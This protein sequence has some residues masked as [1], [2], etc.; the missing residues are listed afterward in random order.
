MGATRRPTRWID[1][2]A[3]AVW[4]RSASLTCLTGGLIFLASARS[5]MAAAEIDVQ[6]PMDVSIANGGSRDFGSVNAGTNKTLTFTVRNSGAGGL[7]LTGAPPVVIT[8][9]HAADFTVTAQ[10]AS[11]VPAAVSVLNAGFESP[12]VGP[13][14]FTNYKMD[15]FGWTFGTKISLWEHSSGVAANGWFANAAPQGTQAGVLQGFSSAYVLQKPQFDAGSYSIRFAVARRGSGSPAND[16]SMSIDGTTL[17]IVPHTS[18]PDDNWRYFTV[19]YTCTTSGE[20]TLIFRGSHPDSS[21]VSVLDDVQILGSTTFEVTF[22]PSANGPRTATL[23]IANN[24]GDETPY[25]ITL[26]GTGAR[27]HAFSLAP[28][29]VSNTVAT[30][31]GLV[32][33]RN[34]GTTAWFEWGLSDNFDQRTPTVSVGSGDVPVAVSA[35]LTGLTPG[36]QYSGR[37]VLTNSLGRAEGGDVVF[38]SPAILL[39]G[40]AMLTNQYGATYVETVTA[41]TDGLGDSPVTV[42]GTVNSNG[43]GAYVLNYTSTNLLGGV[44]TA[45][46]TVFV[47]NPSPIVTNWVGGTTNTTA[48]LYASINPTNLPTTA[49]VEWGMTGNYSNKTAAVTLGSGNSSVPFSATVTGLAPGTRYHARVVAAHEDGGI[50]YGANM[51]FG[52]PGIALN[53]PEVIVKQFGSPYFETAEGFDVPFAV[54]A[55][56]THCLALRPDG[57]VASWGDSRRGAVPPGLSNVVAISAGFN[58]SAALRSDGTVETWG[59][60]V[61]PEGV[62]N[63]VAISAADK[64]VLTLHSDGTVV[65]RGTGPIIPSSWNH[66]LKAVAA[67]PLR[68][69]LLH[70]NGSIIMWWTVPMPPGGD[71]VALEAGFDH[72]IALRPDG[73]VAAWMLSVQTTTPPFYGQALVPSGL[74]NVVAV[75]AGRFYSLALRADGTMAGWGDDRFGGATGGMGL[76]NVIAVD[77]GGYHSIAITAAGA[78]YTWGDDYYGIS[79]IPADVRRAP[80]TVAGTVNVFVPGTNILQYTCTNG[81]GGIASA[82]RTVIVLPPSPLAVTLPATGISNTVATLNGTVNPTNLPTTAWFEWGIAGEP[83]TGQTAT[84]DVGSGANWMPISASVSNLTPGVTYRARVVA[85]HADGGITYANEILFASPRIDLN[86][87]ALTVHPFG[88]PYVEPATAFSSPLA[89]EA[90]S[91]HAAVLR[92]NGT[93]AVWGQ[94]PSGEAFVPPGM[95]NITAMS[96]GNGFILGLT[97]SGSIVTWGTNTS[98]ATIVPADLTNA[99]AVSAGQNHSLALRADGTAVGWGNDDYAQVTGFA[100][101]SNITAISAGNQRSLFLLSNGSAAAWGWIYPGAVAVPPGLSDVKAAA[102]GGSVSAALRSN[103]TVVVWGSLNGTVWS[104]V[105]GIAAGANHILALRGDGTLATWAA[106]VGLGTIPPGLSNVTLIAAAENYS[107]AFSGETVVGWGDNQY[108]TL[109]IPANVASF[110]ITSTETVDPFVPGT[111]VLHFVF[112]NALGGVS[113][114]TKTVIVSGPTPLVNT[115]PASQVSNTV[116]TLNGTVNPSGASSTTWFEWGTSSGNLNATAPQSVGAGSSAV[117]VNL[118]LTGLSH[119]TIYFAR[120]AASNINGTARANLVMFGAPVIELNGPAVMTNQAGTAYLETAEALASFTRIR[121]GYSHNLVVRDGVVD[122]WGTNNYG[123]LN[124]PTNL[125]DCIAIS[126]GAVHSLALRANGSVVAWGN[127]TEFQTEVPASATNVTAISSLYAHNLALR[128]DGTVVGWG[129]NAY[130][131]RNIPAGLSNVAAIAAGGVHSLALLSNGTVRTWGANISGLM[132]VPVNATNITAISAG[133]YHSLALRANGTVVN[134]GNNDNGQTNIPSGLSN[135]VSISAGFYHSLALR[136][137]GTVVAWGNGQYGQTNVPAGLGGV[138]AISAGAV[139]NLA[140]LSNGTLVAWGDNSLAGQTNIPPHLTNLTRLPLFVDGSVNTNEPGS[141]VLTYYSTN[142]LGGVGTATRLVFVSNTNIVAS[143]RLEN[144]T[145]LGDGR[146]QL[147]F[148]NAPG[149]SFTALAS[150]NVAMPVAQWTVL[151]P[152]IEAPPGNYQFID[153]QAT[154]MPQRFYMI[155]SP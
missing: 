60:Y 93:V 21:A 45:T 98:G 27:F 11:F 76:A 8:G 112:T 130:S 1:L 154:N 10:P 116:A 109:N 22:A 17:I 124:V 84:V 23:S 115:L 155:R 141:Y 28:T 35:N 75:S 20:Y 29:G 120:V 63:V 90:G 46:R 123:Q 81:L 101:L 106:T 147:N 102:T 39:N 107:L 42:S 9:P 119:G 48:T 136:A 100:G 79:Q 152:P 140:L 49:W 150:T 52:A 146:L 40:P 74:S 16:I 88:T 24:D 151:G 105:V 92:A 104:N 66:D 134:W 53:G 85:L 55:G 103:G 95:T 114:A 108:G 80:V 47:A 118:N 89:M 3:L 18:Q 99:I 36:V 77:G 13:G 57:T 12:G 139:H 94:V 65:S 110:P 61:L 137:N 126:A 129:Y 87:P 43:P 127:N 128:T 117:A 68:D 14:E 54:S 135:V 33:P 2:A 31:N 91:Q 30:L 149:A 5:A 122:A 62:S 59:D 145:R 125:N 86:G 138:K 132:N 26:T 111:N 69:L 133:L 142:T 25:E 64:H 83:Y 56:E 19:P 131:Q 78:V 51:A 67:G 72:G 7:F 143:F 73:T 34:T 41:F 113:T 70:S 32:N 50:T 82:T 37:V 121:A 71:F 153:A 97:A 44:G 144:V 96:V 6:S 38:G 4:L 15:G 148:S 58:V